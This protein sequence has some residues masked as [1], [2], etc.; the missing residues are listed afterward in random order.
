MAIQHTHLSRRALSAVV[1]YVCVCLC[2]V[3]LSLPLRKATV[4]GLKRS[5]KKE[6]KFLVNQSYQMSSVYS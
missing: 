6:N 4:A 3:Q 1:V 2:T 5:I